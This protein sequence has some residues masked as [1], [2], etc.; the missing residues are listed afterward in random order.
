MALNLGRTG[1]LYYKKESSYANTGVTFSATDALRHIALQ[2]AFQ[3]FNRVISPEKT[4]AAGV[5]SR[6]DRRQSA[7]LESLEAVLRPS[8]TLNTLSDADEIFECAFGAKTNVTLATTVSSGGTTTGAT[9]ASA[10]TLAVGDGVLITRSGVKYVRIL[11]S[12]AGAVV[13]WAPA[14]PTAVTNGESVKGTVSYKG[15][16][17]LALSLAFAHYTTNY[18]RLLLGV[19][20]NELTLKFDANEE[21]RFELSGNAA[22]MKVVSGVPSDPGT[23]TPVGTIVPSGLVGE[24]LVNDTV[25]KFKH[26]EAMVNNTLAVRNQEYGVAIATESYRNGKREVKISLE[27]FV[28]NQTVLHDLSVAGTPCSILKQTGRTEGSI[29]ACWSP[30][31]DF[32]VPETDDPDEALSWSYEGT[33]LASADGNNDELTL[34]LA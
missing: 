14:L 29:I 2:M 28:E 7:A 25:Y 24:L 23:F 11:Q 10:G 30:K 27:T 6:F 19:G 31:V 9:L 32:D 18:N 16:T 21:P 20:A 4:A 34:V 26:Y 1:R 17:A 12:V 13:T 3:P 15:T 8:G 33:A 5:A 22:D